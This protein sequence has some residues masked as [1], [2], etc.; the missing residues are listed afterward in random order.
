[1]ADKEEFSFI[2]KSDP[3]EQLLLVCNQAE[4]EPFEDLV[5]E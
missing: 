2:V 1:M 5:S 3:L 4:V